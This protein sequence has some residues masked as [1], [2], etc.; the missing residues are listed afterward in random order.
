MK[1][2]Y[3]C[4][5]GI[6]KPNKI[7]QGHLGGSYKPTGRISIRYIG[8]KKEKLNEQNALIC[9]NIITENGAITKAKEITF[10]GAYPTRPYIITTALGKIL[11]NK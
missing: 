8:I 1:L 5:Q 2:N 10:Y 7:K 4:R 6:I 3:V 9:M 11:V